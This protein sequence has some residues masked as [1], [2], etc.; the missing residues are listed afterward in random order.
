MAPFYN[1]T[2]YGTVV[3]SSEGFKQKI[4][5]NDGSDL[6]NTTLATESNLSIPLGGYERIMGKYTIWYDSDDTNELKFRVATLAQSDGSTA[7]ASTI[8]TDVTARVEESVAADT[9]AAANVEGTG[10][11]S[12]DGEGEIITV[13]VGAATSG[14][15]LGIEFNVLVTAATKSSLVF[16]AALITGT[17]SGTHLLAGSN[18]V[19][20]KW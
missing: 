15:F 13:D 6:A 4:L 16:Q 9:P 17:S 2:T 1:N 11:Y 18:I 5:A 10:T 7:V 20:K 3:H 8:Y 12:V 19:Y 14:L